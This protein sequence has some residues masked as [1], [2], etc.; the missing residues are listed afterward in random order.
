MKKR[1]PTA[2]ATLLGCCVFSSAI[3]VSDATADDATTTPTGFVDTLSSVK[4]DVAVDRFPVDNVAYLDTSRSVRVKLD[5][6]SAVQDS[7]AELDGA[8]VTVVRPDGKASSYAPDANGMI[9]I[10]NVIP[11]PHAIIA[12]AERVH[13]AMLYYFD[14]APAN[15]TRDQIGADASGSQVM[16]TMLRIRGKELRAAIDRCRS[17]TARMNPFDGLGPMSK[18]FGYSVN[19]GDE[20]TLTGQLVPFGNEDGVLSDTDVTIYFNGTAVGTTMTDANGRFQI[21]GLRPGVHGLVASGRAG[22]S[23]FAFD[24]YDQGDVAK[25]TV[26]GQTLVSALAPESDVLPVVLVPP[27]MVQTLVQ[28]VESSVPGVQDSQESTD[29]GDSIVDAPLGDPIGPIGGAFGQTPGAPGGGFAGGGGADGVGIGGLAGLAVTGA[30][31]AA[32]SDDDNNAIAP[33]PIA[34]PSIPS[35]AAG[36]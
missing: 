35:V 9:A 14:E 20:G 12:S 8:L 25:A 5:M 34:S 18:R 31:I 30:L 15:A 1:N 29:L 16:M 21:A 19:L 32:T 7:T 2:I 36:N 24:A 11:G 4:S 23:A 17:V 28:V 33:A 13:G 26:G 10:D 22:Y 27:P 6:M 3:A